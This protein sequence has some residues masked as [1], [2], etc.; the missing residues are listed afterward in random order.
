MCKILFKS[1]C[2]EGILLFGRNMSGPNAV[3]PINVSIQQHNNES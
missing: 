3:K 1:I 2:E